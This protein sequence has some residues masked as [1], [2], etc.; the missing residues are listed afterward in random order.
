MAKKVLF[1]ACCAI[2]IIALAYFVSALIMM[3]SGQGWMFVG[4]SVHSTILLFA[5]PIV[6][7]GVVAIL[8]YRSI[9]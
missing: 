5:V 7:I 6:C 1:I 2:F 8:L 3:A 9:K 4:G